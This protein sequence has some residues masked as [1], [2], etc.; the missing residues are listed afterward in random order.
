MSKGDLIGEIDQHYYEPEV[1]WPLI[2]VFV[3]EWIEHQGQVED[4]ILPIEAS[5]LAAKWREEMA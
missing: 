5:S 4:E 2:V 3:A 1:Y